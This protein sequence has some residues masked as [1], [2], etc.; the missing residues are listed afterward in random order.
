MEEQAEASS[1]RKP[2][3]SARTL[4]EKRKS[5]VESEFVV[6]VSL[7]LVSDQCGQSQLMGG[8]G[9]HHRGVPQGSASSDNN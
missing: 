9:T 6:P 1:C 8:G 3:M 5:E 7:L 2:R 4:M